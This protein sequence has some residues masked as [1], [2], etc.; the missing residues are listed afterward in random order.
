MAKKKETKGYVEVFPD[1]KSVFEDVIIR[2][3]IDKVVNVKILALDSQKTIYK[4]TKSNAL[5]KHQT[6]ID[7]FITINQRIFEGLTEPQKILQVEESL[8][9]ISWTG[10]KVEIKTGDIKTY[11]GLL[12]QYGYGV[13]KKG[14][15]TSYEVLQA[16]LKS[17]YNK[18]K[19]EDD[20]ANAN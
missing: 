10:E 20:E 8:A 3:G 17:L 6:N 1:V 9:G 15:D 16:T 13:S 11:S 2:T 14:G 5:M 18:A 4:L 7:V 19:E 12:H